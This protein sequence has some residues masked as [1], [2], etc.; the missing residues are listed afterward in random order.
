[1]NN[2]ITAQQ[3]LNALPIIQKMMNYNLPIKAAYSIF[4]LAKIINQQ[5]EFF[6]Q[7]ERDLITQHEA[8]ILDGGNVRFKDS[9][10]Q[11]EFMKA[12]NELMSCEIEG[13]ESITLKFDDFKDATFTPAEIAALEGVI[14]LE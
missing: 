7:K 8:E 3:M 10:S 1:M 11:I 13:L 9:Q 2:K 4:N 6:T 5:Q 14:E 12:H